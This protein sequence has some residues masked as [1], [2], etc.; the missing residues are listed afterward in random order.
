MPSHAPPPAAVLPPPRAGRSLALT[1][2]GWS[3]LLV[4]LVTLA[5]FEFRLPAQIRPTWGFA[6]FELAVNCVLLLI[7]GALFR[8]AFPLRR[9]ALAVVPLLFG[10]AFS[11]AIEL[12]Q[13]VM[14]KI[15][16][17]VVIGGAFL[18]GMHWL[19]KRKNEIAAARDEE[20]V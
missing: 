11:G 7:P 1:L 2:L 6:P 4:A 9:D 8:A 10:L 3:L 17:A 13:T 14:S 19:T 18:L 15:P 20:D 16:G 12:T 5:P